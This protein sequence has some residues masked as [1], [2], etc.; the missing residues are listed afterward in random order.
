MTDN[1]R[2][3]IIMAAG[4]TKYE[5]EKHLKN[6]TIIYEYD[7]YINNASGYMYG[8]EE[9]DQKKLLEAIKNKEPNITKYDHSV[10]NYENKWYVIEYAL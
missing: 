9:E 7:D 1:K 10:V 2:I 6:G 5:A 3:E 4:S 8:L